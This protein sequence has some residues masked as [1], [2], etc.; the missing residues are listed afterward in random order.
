MTMIAREKALEKIEEHA[1]GLLANTDEKYR[2]K[3]EIS[4]KVAHQ[5]FMGNTKTMDTF[6]NYEK[7][8]KVALQDALLD[9]IS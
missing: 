9:S 6:K 4:L 5:T 7:I 3:R 2:P 1:Y 8:Y